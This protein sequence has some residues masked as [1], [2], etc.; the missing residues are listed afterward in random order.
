MDPSHIDIAQAAIAMFVLLF[1]LTVHEFS[2]A[3]AANLLGDPTAELEG[4]LTLNPI[5]HI[6][7]FGTIVFPL[8][9]I[10]TNFPVFGWAKPVPI[11]PV[12][13]SRRIRMKTGILIVSAAGP[14]S[15]V[16]LALL[17]TLILWLL[18]SVFG[19]ENT[20]MNRNIVML[21]QFMIA[22]N[23]LLAFFNI[24]PIPPLDGSKI[25]YGLLPDE[26]GAKFLAIE[27]Y[28]MIFLILLLVTGALS[29]LLKPAIAIMNYLFLI[30]M[31]G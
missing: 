1:S 12:L 11:N 18:I 5:A 13:F 17:S 15:N 23:V 25:L 14:L 8:I 30:A 9:G 31:G 20:P 6:D 2:H 21:F 10:L 26:A 4:R 28:S 24:L 22:I 19:L 29:W 27:R 7:F 16:V 3:K